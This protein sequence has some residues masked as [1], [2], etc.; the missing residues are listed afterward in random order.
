M[1]ICRKCD[2][3]VF[4][5][6]N[7]RYEAQAAFTKFLPKEYKSLNGGVSVRGRTKNAVNGQL[8]PDSPNPTGGDSA[9]FLA[10]LGARRGFH[11][12]VLWPTLASGWEAP[13]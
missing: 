11:E 5:A 8:S 12:R 2:Y 4:D 10:V 1:A 3:P 13:C 6:F 7:H 9:R